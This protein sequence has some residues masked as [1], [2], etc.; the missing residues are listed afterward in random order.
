MKR[1]TKPISI[2]FR[3]ATLQD[4]N[5]ILKVERRAFDTP[6]SKLKFTDSFNNPNINTQ[7]VLKN[8]QIVGYLL[9]LHSIDFV[10]VL[11]LCIDPDCQRQKLGKK[12]LDDLQQRLEKGK[13]QSILLEVRVSNT[14][15]IHFYRY[16]GFEWVDTRKKYYSNGEDAK[17]LC[18]KIS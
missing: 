7:L 5:H 11:N 9:T 13:V 8:D 15:A 3:V 4:I 14:A 12:L 17:I 2:S 6:W 16:Y 10:D 1:I 18:L